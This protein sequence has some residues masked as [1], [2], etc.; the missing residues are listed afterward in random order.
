ME[1]ARMA[2]LANAEDLK[3]SEVIPLEGSSPSS[4]TIYEN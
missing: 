2:K 3:S 1:R 4:G